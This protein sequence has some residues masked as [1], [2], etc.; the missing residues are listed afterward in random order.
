MISLIKATGTKIVRYDDISNSITKRRKKHDT[1]HN[2]LHYLTR[3]IEHSGYLWHMLNDNRFPKNKELLFEKQIKSFY[4]KLFVRS[5]FVQQIELEYIRWLQY[6]H[7]FLDIPENI[8][9]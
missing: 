5:C 9:Y 4:N 8:F 7:L 1:K 3:Q 6:I 2:N